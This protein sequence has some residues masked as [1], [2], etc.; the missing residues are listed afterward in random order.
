[1][2]ASYAYD[3]LSHRTGVTY[4]NGAGMSASFYVT[5]G[6]AHYSN[7]LQS[8]AQDLAGTGNDPHYAFA[9]TPAHQLQSETV[10]DS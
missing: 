1:M 8:L 9:Y 10:S 5:G 4:A 6:T 7:D 2:L 3:P